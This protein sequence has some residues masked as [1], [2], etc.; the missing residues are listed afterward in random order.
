MNAPRLRD[1]P[2]LVSV[3]TLTRDRPDMLVRAVAS[4]AG[5]TGVRVQHIVVGD[6]CG[7]LSDDSYRSKLLAR[8]PGVLLR[9]VA[10]AE[11]PALPADYLPA[12]LASL[13]NLGTRLSGGEF[14]AQLD[15]DNV[16]RP[17]HLLSLVTALDARPDAEAAHSWRRV[18]N[19]DG[20]P[21]AF[22][23]EDPW[24]PVTDKRSAS[25]RRLLSLGVF[26]DGSNEV[27]DTLVA[28]GHVVARVDTSEYLVRRTLL[29]R[30]PFPET[31]SRWRRKL[32]YT[33]D[34]AFSHELVKQKVVVVKS[35]RATLDYYLGG[36]SNLNAS[37]KHPRSAGT[38]D[39]EV[40]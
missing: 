4:A 30:I 25:Y 12:R 23:S 33:E 32:G 21:F 27:R 28:D 35:E 8:F 6:D 10:A 24:H 7:Y 34:V 13:R 11:H 18:L 5:Q 15:D 14:V 38:A 36:Y 39:G 1:R 19:P 31:Y 20:T 37:G 16:F 40:A 17:G 22:E 2:A 26:V 3:V 29:E 9:D